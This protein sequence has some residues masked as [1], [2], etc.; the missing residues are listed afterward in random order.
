MLFTVHNTKQFTRPSNVFSPIALQL[1]INQSEVRLRNGHVTC[2]SCLLV[3]YHLRSKQ[4]SELQ[5]A[6]PQRVGTNSMKLIGSLLWNSLGDRIKTS[7]SLAIFK[8]GIKAWNG[9][10]MQVHHF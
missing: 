3:K 5:S 10:S 2:E 6:T 9:T 8:K 1:K 4:F 7:Q